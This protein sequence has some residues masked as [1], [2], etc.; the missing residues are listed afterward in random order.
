MTIQVDKHKLILISVIAVLVITVI[1]LLFTVFKP[2]GKTS[3]AYEGQVSA[4]DSVIKYKDLL[5]QEK[6]LRISEKDSSIAYQFEIIKF[7]DSLLQI[8]LSNEKRHVS[9]YNQVPASVRNLSKD[10]LRNE[11]RSFHNSQ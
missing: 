8:N 4:L 7:K 5:I 9:N 2:K 3:D 11:V 10:A 6:N 1:I